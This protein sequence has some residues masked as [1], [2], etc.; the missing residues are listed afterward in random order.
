[1]HDMIRSASVLCLGLM[2]LVGCDTAAPDPAPVPTP[3]RIIASSV[4]ATSAPFRPVLVPMGVNAGIAV[5][6]RQAGA[7]TAQI[8][9]TTRFRSASLVKIFIAVDY[10]WGKGPGY[11]IPAED[12]TRFQLMLR[13][14][15]DAAASYFYSKIGGEPALV[16]TF[17]RLSLQDTRP[18]SAVGLHG[19]GSTTLTANDMVRTYRWLLDEAPAGLRDAIMGHLH[20]S[21]PCGTDKYYQNFGIP[22]AFDAPWSAKQGWWGF[23]DAPADVCIAPNTTLPVPTNPIIKGDKPALMSGRVL[24]TTGTVGDNDRVIVAVLTQ[25]PSGTS[26]PDAYATITALTRSL[27]VPR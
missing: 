12:Q 23:G 20:Q 16:R 9:A 26:F 13:G 5:F 1:M 21:T 19:W 11:A 17:S 22:T 4:P 14:S 6:D 2:V 7:F 15:D 27:P 3:G 18:P 10:L 25:Y 8:N 24:H